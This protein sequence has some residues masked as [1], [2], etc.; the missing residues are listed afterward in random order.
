MTTVFFRVINETEKA[1]ALEQLIRRQAI[2][3]FVRNVQSF[4][5]LPRSPFCYW[6]PDCLR[7]SF[8]VLD[9]FENNGRTAKVGLQTSDNFRFIRCN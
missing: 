5:D 7:R 2:G 6:A 9:R 4:S 8:V 1:G 3:R